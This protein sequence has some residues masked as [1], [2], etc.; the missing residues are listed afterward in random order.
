M[1]RRPELGNVQLYPNR[2]LRD[3]DKNGYVLKFWCPIR[4]TRVRKN[5][6]TRDR[7]E[8]RRIMQECR[9]RL[10][11]GRYIAS[12]GLISE[13]HELAQPR[14]IT[15]PAAPAVEIAHTWDEC[16]DRYR[17]HRRTRV[18]EGSLAHALSRLDI[19]R[20]IID[21]YRVDHGLP[22][23]RDIREDF[24]LE[25]LEY[26]QDRLLDGDEC[27]YEQRS[28]MTVN[29]TMGA[30]MAFARYCHRHRWLGEIPPLIKLDVEDVMKGRPITEAEFQ[31]MMESTVEIVGTGPAESWQRVLSILWESAF[32]VGDVMNFSWD[33][34]LCIVP[35]L[36]NA[37]DIFSTIAIPSS[38]KNKKTQ[39]IPMLPG[40]ESLLRATPVN[41]RHGWIVNPLPLDSWIRTSE[42]WFK[43]TSSDLANL[44]SQY[45]RSAIARACG[46]S[47]AA[48]RKW[49]KE[50]NIT[51]TSSRRPQGEIP[52]NEVRSLRRRAIERNLAVTAIDDSTRLS[53]ERV[54][55]VI[56]EI[57]R[58]AGIVVQQA[59]TRTRKRLKY[60]TAH[61]IRRGCAQRL[62]NA[63]VSAE[64]LK[65]VMRHSDFSTTERF[66]G[67]TRNVQ[68]AANE[69]KRHFSIQ[70]PI[71]SPPAMQSEM[72]SQLD[73]LTPDQLDKL[74]KLLTLF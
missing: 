20:R 1:P 48:V 25:V 31:L 54:G 11:D 9:Q 43:P 59:D 72:G 37:S 32:R 7:R 74:K 33:D 69:L 6:G 47:E 2:P 5:A 24:T 58:R 42:N 15:P 67:A 71:G 38:Q 46:V 4:Q 36:S 21:G 26:V 41:A 53:K 29:T 62:I 16:Y 55:R 56:G 64:T 49:L 28:P 73:Q 44:V 52:D 39:V 19:V 63:G 23:Q 51:I 18:R 8:A 10:L 68:S 3:S 13:T 27:R 12:D 57:G 61:D 65:L 35:T 66:Y 30:V 60:A 14:P 34:S 45:N 40:L 22:E 70:N 17:E 50:A